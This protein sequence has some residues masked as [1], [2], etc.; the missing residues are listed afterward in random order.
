MAMGGEYVINKKAAQ[1][2]GT[3]FLDKINSGGGGAMKLLSVP[4]LSS[5]TPPV[6]SSQNSMPLLSVPSLSPVSTPGTNTVPPEV[7]FPQ[8]TRNSPVRRN[9][10]SLRLE[11]TTACVSPRDRS[12]LY[13]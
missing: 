1:R 12:V 10:V 8:G 13:I 4:S 6:T 7:Y 3:N 11:T 5:V 9:V 2:V